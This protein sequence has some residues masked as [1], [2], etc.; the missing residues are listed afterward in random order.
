VT[1][2]P[3]VGPLLALLLTIGW[4]AR[5]DTPPHEPESALLQQ[6]ATPGTAVLRELTDRLGARARAVQSAGLRPA[7]A[8]RVAADVRWLLEEAHR[9]Q[10]A[11]EQARGDDEAALEALYGS[12]EWD[13][14]AYAYDWL[15]CWLGWLELAASGST[16]APRLAAAQAA[17]RPGLVRVWR[18]DLVVQSSRGLAR[19]ALAQHG[20]ANALRLLRATRAS[21]ASRIA[22][23]LLAE[24]D[25]DILLAAAPEAAA[26]PPPAATLRRPNGPELARIRALINQQLRFG[27]GAAEA[28]PLI[29]G[30]LHTGAWDEQLAIEVLRAGDA[31]A[32]QEIGALGDLVVAE[33]AFEHGQYYSAV[34]KYASFFRDVPD[35]AEHGLVRYRY[36]NGFAC[37]R[38]G[39]HACALEVADDLERGWKLDPELSDAT[40]KLRFFAWYGRASE[41]PSA[42]ARE[43]LRQSAQAFLSGAPNDADS[44]WAR[45]ALAS[46]ASG[47]EAERL[48]AQ[49]RNPAHLAGAVELARF[50]LAAEELLTAAGEA[51]RAALRPAA[52]RASALLA[53]V[54]REAARGEPWVQ[55]AEL[56]IEV[57]H[58][59][60]SARIRA[61]LHAAEGWPNLDRYSW[62]AVYWALLQTAVQTGDREALRVETTRTVA[63][64]PDA[65]RTRVLL[66]ALADLGD[67]AL[68][69]DCAT[70]LANWSAADPA[71]RAGALVAAARA[72]LMLGDAERAYAQALAAVR[73]APGSV[74]ARIAYAA[75]CD[76][77]G[78]SMEASDVWHDAAADGTAP[79]PRTLL[80]RLDFAAR[81]RRSEP[82]CR[83][84][85]ALK[86]ALAPISAPQ[87]ARLDRASAALSC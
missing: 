40:R 19:V 76:L 26:T 55:A 24:L 21:Y 3:T 41:F 58:S 61:Q 54:P 9:R 10:R 29:L 79:S 46:T 14:L 51:D 73:L 39:L 83:I 81:A 53:R 66:N 62:Q 65:W 13:D 67:A 78:R 70:A 80:D 1:L 56:L 4:R 71:D 37:L 42:A 30:L 45:L 5:A 34:E 27:T 18:P 32:D 20:R 57:V 2:L 25:T 72:S 22:P 74:D 28:A 69:A 43:Q 8:A 82:G 47:V 16:A 84:A 15:P 31:F 75:T 11:L 7:E 33:A 52:D 44:D 64:A 38:A 17:L 23:A 48:L 85:R 77:M 68:A 59:T 63:A 36:R 87:R 12:L 60:L 49:I 6:A 50:R 35:A 86:N